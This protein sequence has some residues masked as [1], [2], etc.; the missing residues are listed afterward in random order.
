VSGPPSLKI[1]KF[2]QQSSNP[3][4]IKTFQILILNFSL[5]NSQRLK[6]SNTDS[7]TLDFQHTSTVLKMSYIH[8]QCLNN[9]TTDHSINSLPLGIIKLVKRHYKTK[10]C[11]VFSKWRSQAQSAATHFVSHSQSQASISSIITARQIFKR[12]LEH[13]EDDQTPTDASSTV[14]Y[15][16]R[17]TPI[18]P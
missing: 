3:I 4:L 5:S 13:T 15:Q 11:V 8:S 6:I 12:D 2:H 17:L 10:H 18:R 16:V 7:Q 9:F 14:N 1:N